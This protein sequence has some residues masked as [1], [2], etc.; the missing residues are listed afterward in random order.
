MEIKITNLEHIYMPKTPFEH[1]ALTNVN[2]H[3][4]SGQFV[5][6]IGHTGSGKSTIVQHLNGLLKPTSGSVQIGQ[7][8]IE[9]NKK[10]K[11]LKQ[12]R[13][14]VGMVFQYPE[15]QLFDETVEK[16][17]AF[18]PINFGVSKEEAFRLVKEVLPL[19]N[20]D[21]SVLQKSPFDLSGGQKRRVAIAGVLASKPRVLVLDEPTAGLDPI[22]RKQM[23]ELFLSLHKQEKVTTVLVTHNMEFAAMY[24]DLV[25]VMD[26]GQVFMQ[27]TP[28]EVFKS[29]QQLN[30]IGLDVPETVQ[31]VQML[32]EQF[33]TKLSANIFT[34]EQLVVAIT[35]LLNGEV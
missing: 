19:V 29:R 21:E 16:D 4:K 23:M 20:L 33:N 9:A 35:Q 34:K 32:E 25:I 14:N 26:K 24:A 10:N 15:H 6:I 22:G 3:I 30:E 13:K 8:L 18:G 1:R 31:L 27:G 12:L 2:I 7:L 5:A 17:I 11:E 28:A